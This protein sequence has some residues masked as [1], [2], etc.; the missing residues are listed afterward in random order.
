MLNLDQDYN[1]EV[2]SAYII[3]V[4]DNPISESMFLRCTRS[5][6]DVGM[7]WK[8]WEAFDGTSGEIKTPDHLKS[9]KWLKWI[10]KAN[11]GLA[12]TE[13]ALML[14][15]V[16]L[17]EH[18]ISINRPIVILEHD[19]FM[20]RKFLTHPAFNAIIYLGSLEQVKNNFYS[21]L[22]PIMGQLNPNYRFI[23][24]THAYSIDPIM[25]RRLFSAVLTDGITTSIDVMI[26]SDIYTQLQMGIYA[27]DMADNTSLCYDRLERNENEHLVRINNKIL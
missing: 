17:W 1:I 3:T 21:S 27:F 5:C 24:R 22:I 8:R 20:V 2:E 23:L 18:C 15:S 4:K 26:R 13:I 10:K 16:A 11:D 14:T 7:P 6:H 19:A 12:P 25:A 9:E